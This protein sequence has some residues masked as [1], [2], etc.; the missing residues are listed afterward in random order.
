MSY[1]EP[2]QNE[3]HAAWVDTAET[4]HKR[5]A[6]LEDERDIF[7]RT[8]DKRDAE[9]DQAVKDHIRCCETNNENANK[10]MWAEE[11]IAELEA[12][13]NALL[14]L[15]Q[16]NADR[17]RKRMAECE[18]ANK[19]FVSNNTSLVCENARLKAKIKEFTK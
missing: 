14:S 16:S 18:E 3:I 8:L 2:T 7:K 6:E 15:S 4:L 13:I 17:L 1:K 19:Y 5:I 11:R 9:R 10:R 12:E